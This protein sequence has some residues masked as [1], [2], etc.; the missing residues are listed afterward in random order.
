[1]PTEFQN[2]WIIIKRVIAK[3]VSV[4]PPCMYYAI[5]IDRFNTPYRKIKEFHNDAQ[6]TRFFT[7]VL[8]ADRL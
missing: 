6:T 1:M 2:F 3:M 8:L 7:R 5:F 4:G